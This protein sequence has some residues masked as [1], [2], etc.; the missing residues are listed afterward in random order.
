MSL[1]LYKIHNCADCPFV[2][3][4]KDYYFGNIDYHE[5]NITKDKTIK[6]VNKT[7]DWCPAKES[8]IEI[9]YWGKN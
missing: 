9:N 7:P 4:V 6:D 3:E 2:V 1:I 8:D 5:C